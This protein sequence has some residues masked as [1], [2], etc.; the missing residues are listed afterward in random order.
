MIIIPRGFFTNMSPTTAAAMLVFGLI[1]FTA[2]MFV[3]REST[4]TSAFMAS[5]F[6][7]GAVT[8]LSGITGLAIYFLRQLH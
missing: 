6:L 1:A 4:F 2:A 8:T 7:L 5:G 3:K